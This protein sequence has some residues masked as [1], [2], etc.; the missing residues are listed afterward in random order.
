VKN[1]SSSQHEGKSAPA[2]VSRLHA[3]GIPFDW[4]KSE[5]DIVLVCLCGGKLVM[6][7]ARSW[8]HCHGDLRCRA[9]SMTFEQVVEALVEK[10]MAT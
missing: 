5:H 9:R 1:L 10:A 3:A 4:R 7:E 6:D 8:H 2:N